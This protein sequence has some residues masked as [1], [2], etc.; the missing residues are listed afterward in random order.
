MS[1][2][3]LREELS[4]IMATNI[5]QDLIKDFSDYMYKFVYSR[6]FCPLKEVIS[7]QIK[8]LFRFAYQIRAAEEDSLPLTAN[9]CMSSLEDHFLST[10]L[11]DTL[12][13]MMQTLN[14]I[15]LISET[16]ELVQSLITDVRRHKWSPQ[17]VSS[18]FTIRYCAYCAGYENF[19][20]CDGNCLNVLRGCTADMAEL[21]KEVKKV[22][23]L[24]LKLAKLAQSELNPVKLVRNTLID[25]VLL[26]KHLSRFNFTDA[27]SY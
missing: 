8:K 26:G 12:Q 23:N 18:L 3:L 14:S 11:N 25:Y 1:T 6:D 16:F 7:D 27:V 13:N 10:W 9:S 20:H 4:D 24:L 22:T 5:S 15:R 17:C 2:E 19:H 21:Q